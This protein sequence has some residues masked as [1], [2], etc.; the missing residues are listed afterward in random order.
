MIK[1]SNEKELLNFSN[2]K[3]Y[4]YNYTIDLNYKILVYKN[5]ITLH[6]YDYKNK[7]YSQCFYSD[8][9]IITNRWKIINNYILQS[10]SNP[11]FK[12]YYS[13]KSR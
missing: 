4:Y 8:D 13:V 5:K 7:K 6:K 10:K 2:K 11:N 1:K 3:T 9:K 12:Y